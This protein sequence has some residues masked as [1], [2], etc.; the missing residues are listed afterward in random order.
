MAALLFPSFFSF[1]FFGG[2]GGGVGCSSRSASR[3]F[4]L[5]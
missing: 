3:V 2:G 4:S 5:G 1:F